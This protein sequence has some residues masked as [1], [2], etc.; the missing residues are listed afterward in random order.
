MVVYEDLQKDTGFRILVGDIPRLHALNYPSKLALVDE[1]GSRLSWK[2]F[3]E[4]ACRLANALCSLGLTQG[5]RIAIIG[6]NSQ[7]YAEFCFAV[8]KANLVAVGINNRLTGLQ[9]LDIL[10][11][12]EPKAILVEKEFC[13]VIDLIGTELPTVRHTIGFGEGHRY[14]LDYETLLAEHPDHEPEVKVSE[15]SLYTLIYT[16]GT[17]GQPKGVPITHSHWMSGAWQVPFV[18]AGYGLDDIAMLGVP[19]NTAAGL[20][21]LLGACLAG[22]TIVIHRFS[23]KSFSELIEREKVTVTYLGLTQYMIVRDY[24]DTCARTYDLNSLRSVL[25]GSRPMPTNKLKE[26]LDF[27]K[28]AYDH[29]YRS[30]GMTELLPSCATVLFGEDIAQGLRPEATEKER[31]RVDSVG[32]PYLMTVRVVDDYGNDVAPG[33]VGEIIVKGAW[34]AT[35]YWNKPEL[36]RERFKDGWFYTRDLGT[37]DEDG[38][39][40][41]KGRK[42]FQI[43]SGQLFVSPFEVENAVLKHPA[44]SEVAVIGVPDEKWGEAV[45]ALVCL[46]KGC[47]A[48]EDEIKSHCRKY[49]AGFQVPKSVDFLVELPKDAQGKVDLK[50]LRRLYAYH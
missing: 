9:I 27:F 19:L 11:D 3:N 16:S 13:G 18:Y 47:S 43:K 7:Q 1:T 50:G 41:F 44:V 48:T 6:Q 37:F 29:T 26:M 15:D 10:R 22:V 35:G 8:A 49:L 21:Q 39:L 14:S 31:R 25:V 36:S 32:K 33:E 38:Y 30:L 5:D 40:Y 28:I 23:A 42:D 34:V 45:K 4:R 24:L 17:T 46:K 20:V 2:Q 12:C